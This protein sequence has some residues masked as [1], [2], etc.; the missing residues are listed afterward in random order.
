MAGGKEG[1]VLGFQRI[2]HVVAFQFVLGVVE[3]CRQVGTALEI[4]K[5]Q[6]GV[7]AD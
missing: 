7:A 1:R 6:C 3:Q 2:W 5:P 4:G